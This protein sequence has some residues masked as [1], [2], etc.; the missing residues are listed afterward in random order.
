M[1]EF[2]LTAAPWLIV[3]TAVIRILVL[4]RQTPCTA[5]S[6]GPEEAPAPQE[7]RYTVYADT[8]YENADNRYRFTLT[9]LPQGYRCYID[10]TPSYRSRS[11]DP[12]VIH[13]LRDG[14]RYYICYTAPLPEL[15]QAK[16]LCRDWSNLTQRYIETGKRFNA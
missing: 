15:E 12:N 5:H 13:R 16:T 14:D 8:G 11:M 2:T 3:L 9:R 1:L 10:R 4:C 6:A 7:I